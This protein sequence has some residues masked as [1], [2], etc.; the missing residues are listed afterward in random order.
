[1]RDDERAAYF[2]ALNPEMHQRLLHI[3]EIVRTFAPQ[4]E[5]TFG[6]QMPAFR[7][8]TVVLYYAAF[9]KH[10]GLFPGK[11][12]VEFIRKTAP[13]WVSGKATIQIPHSS[14]I[15][16]ELIR[17]LITFRLEAARNEVKAG[18]TFS[19]RMEA[20]D[21]S[22]GFDFSGKFI[23]V[24]QLKHLSILLDDNRTLDVWFEEQ[25]GGVSVTE[26]FEAENM[27]P[28]ELQQQGWQAI[29]DGYKN[30]CQSVS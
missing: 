27:N 14:E 29:L 2:E 8:Q 26:E 20:R 7:S 12:A 30:Y 10:I 25:I 23:A 19:Y 18:G 15:P 9:K 21:G 17:N 6:Y 28:V 16:D 4:L 1:M 11:A 22:M 3:R 13:Q 24:E 5:E